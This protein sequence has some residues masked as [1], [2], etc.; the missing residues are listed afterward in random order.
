[1]DLEILWRNSL[2]QGTI[3][4]LFKTAHIVPIHKGGSKGESKNYRPVALTSH[5]IKVF[6]KVLRTHIIKHMEEHNLFNPR[7][8]GFR[9]GRSCLSQ[10]IAH[11]DNIMY[12][13]EQGRNVD[14]VYLDFSKAFDKVDFLI[15]LRKINALGIK[16]KIG[17]W[18]QCFL[19]GRTQSVLVDGEQSKH[20]PVKSGVPQGSVLG[21]ILF[22][23]LLGYIDQDILSSVVSSFADDSRVTK[24][25]SDM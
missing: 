8:H 6:E 22:L 23:I 19:T 21:P 13:L 14:V 17:K 1:M 16:G 11:F 3:P 12:E 10:L 4:Q 25:I 15:T 7:Q 24:G 5:L 20:S 18:I 2:D 9:M